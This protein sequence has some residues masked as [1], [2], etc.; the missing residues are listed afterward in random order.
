MTNE[1]I[2]TIKSAIKAL[3]ENVG[4]TKYMRYKVQKAELA[5]PAGW[6]TYPDG[7]NSEDACIQRYYNAVYNVYSCR[8]NS[9]FYVNLMLDFTG[10]MFREHGLNV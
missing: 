7:D 5:N 6:G 9:G 2:Q 8:V 1:T 4:L 3:A 10:R